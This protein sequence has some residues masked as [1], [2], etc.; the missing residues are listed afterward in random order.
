MKFSFKNRDPGLRLQKKM[1]DHIEKEALKFLS[2][3]VLILTGYDW[4]QGIIGII[5]SKIKDKFQKPTILIS[6]NGEKGKGS[7]RSIYAFDI[8]AAF[9]SALKL[10]LIENRGGHKMAGGFSINKNKIDLFKNFIFEKFKKSKAFKNTNNSTF[11]DG[12]ISSSAPRW[13]WHSCNT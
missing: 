8:G 13:A 11:I 7:A 2:D 5:A 6:L 9:I 12:K 4:H 3:P 10:G 1:L